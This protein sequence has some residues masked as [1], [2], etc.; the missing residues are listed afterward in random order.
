MIDWIA[1]YHKN[2]ES[3]PVLSKAQPGNILS[4]LPTKAPEM[5]E[6][7]SEIMKD[8]D[9]IIMPG[10]THWQSPNFF[11]FFPSN[12]SGPSVL[13]EM[14]SAGLG[15]QGMLWL[16]SPACT[17][18]EIKVLDWL[19]DLLDL[20]QMY[21]ST[22]AGGGVI[23]DTAS[24][25]SL[26][27]LL[28]ARH[29]VSEGNAPKTG[30]PDNF[31]A[32]T[33]DQ[34]HSSMAK[35]ANIAGMGTERLRMISTDENFAMQSEALEKAILED[36]ASGGQPFFVAATIGTTSTLANDPLPEIAEICK[37]HHCWLHVDAA[38]SGTAAICEEYR[39]IHKGLENADSYTFNPHKW[40]LT[41]F[42][43]NAFYLKDRKMLTHTMSILPEYLRNAATEK[44]EVVDYRDWQVPLGRRFR[45]LKLWFVLR[46]YGAEHIREMVRKHVGL[47]E[48]LAERIASHP[49]LV[50]AAPLSLN[51]VCFRHTDGNEKTQQIMEEINA[52]GNAY[53]SH[54]KLNE[55]YVI[56]VSVG[57]AKTEK[58]HIDRL[59]GIIEDRC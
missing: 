18:L 38:M 22:G 50:L 52:S 46:M 51:L 58:E 27:A 11:A 41:N 2:V 55:H 47:A 35:A 42:D 23:Q 20:P 13:G 30:M 45:A 7:F 36:K 40:M 59:W 31:A 25:A 1:D 56:R 8:V 21:K 6:S 19:V 39:K 4:K 17:E 54:T 5:P 32:Y 3:Y 14:L 53:L 15:V 16:T 43:C 37:K 49:K 10:I 26:C 9:D 57:Q 44:S 34:A 29:Q 33:S 12:N 24:S 48:D 28:A